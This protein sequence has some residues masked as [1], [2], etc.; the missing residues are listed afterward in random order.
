MKNQKNTNT[1][2]SVNVSALLQGIVGRLGGQAAGL[3]TGRGGEKTVNV[4]AVNA[5]VANVTAE[6]PRI[7][8]AT[9]RVD[10]AH[11]GPIAVVDGPATSFDGYVERVDVLGA[12]A[13]AA[14]AATAATE[15]VAYCAA[16]RK[17]VTINPDE[18]VRAVKAVKN[19]KTSWVAKVVVQINKV[20]NERAR[21]GR[22]HTYV[23]I[24]PFAGSVLEYSPANTTEYKRL[25]LGLGT[26]DWARRATPSANVAAMFGAD[27]SAASG[28]IVIPERAW[29]KKLRVATDE[30]AQTAADLSI[31]DKAACGGNA[32]AVAAM[33]QALE[34]LGVDEET[35]G[36]YAASIARRMSRASHESGF[37]KR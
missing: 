21:T 36:E 7:G 23:S 37:I 32:A 28:R 2:T 26:G 16:G 4:A 14:T 35:Q 5:A 12:D 29:G 19:A 17:R 27:A 25:D 11:F 20:W 6:S 34:T 30:E 1:S 24:A 9:V 22:I 33:T 31:I 18:F 13:T 3:A 15:F 10:R 8:V